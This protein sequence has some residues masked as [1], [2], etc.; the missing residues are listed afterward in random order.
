MTLPNQVYEKALEEIVK[1]ELN[2]SPDE[3]DFEFSAGS[4]K[5]DNY[6]G[7]VYRI[8]VKS[9][10]DESVKLNLVAKLPPLNDAR[11][12]QFS[13]NFCF[14]REC[15]FYDKVYPMYRQFQEEKDI[16]VSVDGFYH[17]PKCFKTMTEEPNEALFFEDLKALKFEMFD[18]LKEVTRDQVLLV[19]K[20]LAKMHAIS[21]AIQDQKP[22]L[23]EPYKD[24]EDFFIHQCNRIDS[25]MKIWFESLKKQGDEVLKK[26]ENLDLINRVEAA[27]EGNL[28]KVVRDCTE[29]KEFGAITHGDVRENFL[30]R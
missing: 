11:R 24:F 5:G 19:M 4:A 25:G 26:S 14:S 17:I 16:D 20:A 29:Y 2:L 7:V 3:C 1:K 15:E 8:V 27:L 18:R 6:L 22:E 9:K 30:M 13:A 12:E 23:M 21:F 10:R 28:E